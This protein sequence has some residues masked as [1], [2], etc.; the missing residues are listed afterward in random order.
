M[1]DLK[2]QVNK[3]DPTTELRL[4][5]GKLNSKLVLGKLKMLFC[6]V[7]MTKKSVKSVETAIITVDTPPHQ[8]SLKAILQS[9]TEDIF[10]LYYRKQSMTLMASPKLSNC[11]FRASGQD[12]WTMFRKTFLGLLW[13]QCHLSYFLLS[14]FYIQHTSI[15]YQP[16]KM[17]NNN[18]NQVHPMQ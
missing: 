3:V 8:K 5:A 15:S 16:Q 6:L 14:S 11:R 9:L 4:Y 18:W 1:W 13:W 2:I 7:K 10:Q 12:G 17:E